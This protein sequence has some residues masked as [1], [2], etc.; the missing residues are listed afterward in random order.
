MARVIWPSTNGNSINSIKLR[1]AGASGNEFDCADKNSVS[2][3]GV[4]K[5]PIMLDKL[6]LKIA[7]GTFPLAIAVMAMEE[8]RVEGKIHNNK[9]PS[10]KLAGNT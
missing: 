6:A 1:M 5:M 8:E 3:N 10:T 7:V 4:I 9:K 2:N